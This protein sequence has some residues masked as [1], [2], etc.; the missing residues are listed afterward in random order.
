[1]EDHRDDPMIRCHLSRLMGEK[2]VRVS[3]VARVTGISRNMLSKLYYDRAQ[4][5]DV[6]DLEKLCRFFSCGVADLLEWTPGT[7]SGHAGR[8]SR[9]G[10]K[11]VKKGSAPS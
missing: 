5:I 1:M 3:D 4:R 10:R 7:V 2:R 8:E 6:S 9:S 11:R